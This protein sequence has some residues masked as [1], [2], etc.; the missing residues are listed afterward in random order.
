[1]RF[2]QFAVCALALAACTQAPPAN[3]SD[4]K[5]TCT[6][7][8]TP[9]AAKLTPGKQPDGSVLL[10]GGRRLTPAGTLYTLGGFP[11]SMR[12]LPA[13]AGAARERY[14]VVSDGGLATNHLRLIDLES[15]QSPIV[16]EVA[17]SYTGN[18][19]DPALFYGL[20]LT[21]DGARLYVSNGGYD[22]AQPSV[23]ADQHFNTVEVYA[24]HVAD[25][26]PR[27]EP[28]ADQTIRLYFNGRGNGAIARYPAGIAL[29]GDETRLYAATQFDGTLAVVSVAPG[30]EYGAEIGRTDIIGLA[31]NDIVV[32]E[33]AGAPRAYVT[34]WGGKILGTRMWADGVIPVDLTN[35]RMPAPAAMPLPTGKAAYAMSRAGQKLYVATPDADEIAILDL[36]GAEAPKRVPVDAERHAAGLLGSSPNY[37]ATDAARDRLYVA[38]ANENAVEAFQLSTMR[39]LGH[40]PTAW[41][42][43]AVMVLSDGSLVISSG[44]GLGGGPTNRS[45]GDEGVGNVY[46]KGTLQLVP[47]PSEA[48]LAAGDRQ[49]R[50]NNERPKSLE[51]PLVCTGATDADK[52]FPL[53]AT[54]SSPSP[55]EHVFLVVRENKTYDSELGDLPGT[56]GDPS[57]TLWTDEI[58]P[59]THALARR[60]AV[61]D[62]FYSNAEQSVQGHAWTTSN[63]SNDYT[64]KAWLSSWGRRTRSIDAY[65]DVGTNRDILGLPGSPTIWTHLDRNNIVYHNY[66][67]AVN[68]GGAKFQYD[69]DYPGVF[70]GLG[71]SDVTKIEYVIK[72]LN[73]P[74]FKVEPFSYI[75]LP[76]DHT[77]G[78]KPGS[79]TPASMI[80][81]NDEATG[82][83]IDALSRS[84]YWATSLVIILED[85]PSDG[86]DHVEM[87][88]SPCVVVSPWIKPGIVSSVNYDYASVY[89]TILR[90]LGVGPMNTYDANAATM[91]DLFDT[92]PHLEPYTY[93]P[94]RIPEQLN[95]SDAPLAAESMAIDWTRPDAAP[96]GRILWKSVK[97][98]DSEPPWGKRPLVDLDLDGD[99]D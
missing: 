37:V 50:D 62:N 63:I 93:I 12:A 66:G 11:L 35:P 32:V 6:V 90:A 77:S 58:T 28:L 81:D 5:S 17:Y 4:F 36:D 31:P 48:E 43:T 26:T 97:G 42:P 88:R 73:D 64:E 46:M 24:T 15:P 47:F 7:G 67:E 41:Y 79:P 3:P 25:A 44:K 39:P 59:N 22:G 72:K 19:T 85:D 98:A 92:A 34:L 70:F 45:V 83:F 53:K 68:T 80:A 29:S 8:E 9:A 27:L 65:S 16:S 76:N 20:A 1:M 84:K 10:I 60:Y 99:G 57:L 30:A 21:R 74:E 61:L 2:D 40:V 52:R 54:P 33:D 95:G 56:N 13:K 86:G 91:V 89:A 51:V 78:S 69:F 82:R 18:A 87:H 23:P 75:G 96:L 55:I 38:N 49:V 71:I 14:V 94:R